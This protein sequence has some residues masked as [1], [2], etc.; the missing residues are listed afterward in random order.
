MRRAVKLYR[1]QEVLEV[2]EVTRRTLRTYE[3]VG[4]VR[5]TGR[6]GRSPLY[7]EEM[8]ETVRRIQRLRQD[9]GVNLAG[10]QVILEMR[11]KIEDLQQSLEDVVEFVQNDL[12]NELEQ[13]LRRQ[14][15]AVIP[16]PL[17]TPRKSPADG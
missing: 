6:E 4:L 17:T 13:Y 15:K 14:E 2:T 5:P 3:E 9:L 10:V 8:V 11:D 16:R 12:R 1:L 7:A